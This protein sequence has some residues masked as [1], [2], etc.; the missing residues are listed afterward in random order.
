MV[1]RKAFLVNPKHQCHVSQCGEH[2]LVPIIK[3]LEITMS[4]QVC[5]IS[6]MNINCN[7]NSG[8]KGFSCKPKHQYRVSQCT[9]HDCTAHNKKNGD[10]CEYR[11]LTYFTAEP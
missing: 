5:L 11:S 2:D 9:K 1:E 4:I 10:Y 3:I 7:E 6:W 8:K